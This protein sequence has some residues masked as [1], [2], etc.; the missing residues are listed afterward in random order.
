M[1]GCVLAALWAQPASARPPWDDAEREQRRS[2]LRQQL[3]AERDRWRGGPPPPH[4][5]RRD[6]PPGPGGPWGGPPPHHV[7]PYGPGGGGDPRGGDGPHRLSPEE[8]RAL[9][10][11]LRQQRP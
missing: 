11:E 2:E 4:D 1:L 3:E 10:Q 6:R 5:A 8:R 9:R 7:R